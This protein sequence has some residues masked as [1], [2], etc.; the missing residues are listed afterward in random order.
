V[1]TARG[2]VCE[3][4]DSAQYTKKKVKKLLRMVEDLVRYYCVL[5]KDKNDHRMLA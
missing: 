3:K 4:P 2:E 1:S 5:A